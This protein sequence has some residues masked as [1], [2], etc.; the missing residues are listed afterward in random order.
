MKTINP[1]NQTNQTN[2]ND[3]DN[4]ENTMQ[5]INHTT[6]TI[7]NDYGIFEQESWE[8]HGY[9]LVR[10]IDT[11][12][13]G[14]GADWK[15]RHDRDLPEL[16]NQNFWAKD[17]VDYGVN[18]SA[19]G[20]RPAADARSYALGLLQAAEAAEAFSKIRNNYSA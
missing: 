18:W 2:N 6:K 5:N 3:K 20:T 15:V 17:G 10:I 8:V 19:M 1:T 7:E 4:K 14:E 11:N 13:P 9:T 16:D 12:A